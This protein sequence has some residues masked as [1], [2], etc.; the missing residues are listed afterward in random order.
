VLLPIIV[1]LV[2]GSTAVCASTAVNSVAATD[3]R[4]NMSIIIIA[5]VFVD[6]LIVTF[7]SSSLYVLLWAYYRM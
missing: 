3:I 4:A 5:I 6:I 1:V 7:L 2:V